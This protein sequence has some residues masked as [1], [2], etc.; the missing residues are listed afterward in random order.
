MSQPEQVG[1]NPGKRRSGFS[2]RGCTYFF[3]DGPSEAPPFKP[4]LPHV[5]EALEAR[6]ARVRQWMK[7]REE[8]Q[9]QGQPRPDGEP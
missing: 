5:R 3:L 9:K 2:S 6:R 4:L 1:P 7:E 8:Q